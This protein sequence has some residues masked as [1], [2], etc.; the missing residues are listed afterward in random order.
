MARRSSKLKLQKVSWAVPSVVRGGCEPWGVIVSDQRVWAGAQPAA[1][2]MESS[3]PEQT[4]VHV[5]DDM[6]GAGNLQSSRTRAKPASCNC[7]SSDGL[8]N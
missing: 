4:A 8:A 2:L 1:S 7:N 6:T 3:P 5:R